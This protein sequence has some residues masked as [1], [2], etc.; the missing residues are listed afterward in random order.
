MT[1][2]SFP[3][4]DAPAVPRRVAPSLQFAIRLLALCIALG[5]LMSASGVNIGA[6]GQGLA[7]ALVGM[8]VYISFRVLNFP[9]L[10]VD[11]A[12]PFGG[13]VAAALIV[14]AGVAAEW[15][16]PAALIAGALLGLCTALIHVLLKIDGLLA[17]IIVMTG[18]FTVVLRVMTTSNI[19][20]INERTI[21]TPLQPIVREWVIA[22]FGDGY[23]RQANN[24]VE[25]IVFSLVVTILLVVVRWFLRT[26]I[27]LTLRAAGKNPQMVRAVGVDHRAMIVIGL[28]LSNGLSALAGALTVQ[29]LGFADVQ[30]GVGIIVRGLAAVMIGETLLRPRTVGQ[31]ILSAVIGMIVFEVL[32]AWVFAALRL[33]AADIRLVSALV[34]LIALAAPTFWERWRGRRRS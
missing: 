17:S 5:L 27:G 4:S 22:T 1:A 29:Q 34:V 21:L 12:F 30:M 18:A 8:G 24:L 15:T 33:E 16:L 20:L 3:V 14:N 26:E 31:G 13:A 10:S 19:P 2:K 25:I 7:L 6:L 32:R 28:M 9:D 11:G 23:R